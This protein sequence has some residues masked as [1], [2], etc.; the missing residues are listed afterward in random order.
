MN[1]GLPQFPLYYLLKR[2]L[3]HCTAPQMIPNHWTANDPELQMIPDVDRK[4]TRRKINVDWDGVIICLFIFST[5]NDNLN[6]CKE[7]MLK[8]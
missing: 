6:K 3:D 4:W 7:K 2:K 8:T 5:S 1:F